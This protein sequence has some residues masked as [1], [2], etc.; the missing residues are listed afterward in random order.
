MQCVPHSQGATTVTVILWSGV[1]FSVH[2]T[3]T[4]YADHASVTLSYLSGR[5]MRIAATR[6][7]PLSSVFSSHRRSVLP[8][9]CSGSI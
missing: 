4:A 2:G 8:W 9:R 3:L 7:V 6:T 5:L 1:I